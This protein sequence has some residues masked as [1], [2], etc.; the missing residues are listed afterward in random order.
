MSDFLSEDE[1][2]LEEE[3]KLQLRSLK[4]IFLQKNPQNFFVACKKVLPNFPN[5]FCRF[6]TK[7]SKIYCRIYKNLVFATMQQRLAP[8]LI[9]NI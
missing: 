6:A 9:L 2:Q 8:P 3:L 7:S 5:L 1:L 4:C